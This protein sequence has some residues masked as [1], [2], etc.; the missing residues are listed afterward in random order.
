MSSEGSSIMDRVEVLYFDVFGTVVDYVDTVTKALR[1]EI[2]N[3]AIADASVLQ[4]LQQ[5]YD[6]RYFT[7][8]WRQ[9]YKLETKRLA[10]IGNP[11]KVTVDQMHMNA[12]NR[13]IADLPLAPGKESSRAV[14]HHATKAVSKALDQAWTQDVRER[15]NFTWHLLEPWADS[16]AGLQALKAHFKLGTLTN[17]NLNLMVDMAKHANLAWDFVLTADMM[18]SFKPDPLMYRKAMQLFDIQLEA[19]AHKACMVAAHVSIFSEN[20][21]QCCDQC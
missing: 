19:D 7:L 9:Q 15:L 14:A 8:M 11:D 18:G 13:L 2:A 16:V 3:T 4:A 1:W 20:S 21:S 6:W 10:D 17:G 5:D 12:L